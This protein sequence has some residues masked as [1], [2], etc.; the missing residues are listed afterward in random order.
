MTDFAHARRVDFNGRSRQAIRAPYFLH[1][2]GRDREELSPD[3]EENDLF[4]A[5]RTGFHWSCEPH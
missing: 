5:Q 4:R 1:G 3:A 2:S